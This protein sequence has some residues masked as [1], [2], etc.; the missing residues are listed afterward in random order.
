MGI[1]DFFKG[2]RNEEQKESKSIDQVLNEIQDESRYDDTEMLDTAQEEYE[3]YE[4]DL[5]QE[6]Y[7]DYEEHEDKEKHIEEDIINID[8]GK[9]YNKINQLGK[10][11]ERDS[12]IICLKALCKTAENEE[13]ISAILE[14]AQN[15]IE[16]Y[17]HNEE[18]LDLLSNEEETEMETIS[19]EELIER[20]ELKYSGTEI[21][22][23]KALAKEVQGLNQEI[24]IRK[25]LKKLLIKNPFDKDIINYLD[26]MEERNKNMIFI[27][28]V[29]YIEALQKNFE[30]MGK[31]EIEIKEGIQEIEENFEKILEDLE[32]E[33]DELVK[34]IVRESFEKYFNSRSIDLYIGKSMVKQKEWK[35]YMMTEP[36]FNKG[37][38]NPVDSIT[39]IEALKFCNKVSEYYGYEPAYK[40]EKNRLSKIV[41]RNKMEVNPE[42]ADFSK[43]EGY[44]LPTFLEAIRFYGITNDDSYGWC[45]DS[46]PE[47]DENEI[48]SMT[49]VIFFGDSEEEA[50]KNT[51]K[52]IKKKYIYQ[53]KDINR[54]VIEN[55]IGIYEEKIKNYYEGDSD[56]SLRI[57]RTANCK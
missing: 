21:V 5:A 54:W 42:I 31:E 48:N 18:I 32:D 57:V 7:V 30:L 44:R 9:L 35:R 37:K 10:R 41:Y 3:N 17:P 28:G 55:N 27:K 50:L 20:L 51:T 24:A 52:F 16:K 22:T 8:I 19:L 56:I 6:E 29:T 47:D 36:S 39:W 46:S 53:N 34:E 15:L 13:N 25:S 14:I 40:I 45:Y 23:I 43:V 33:E 26:S 49:D 38:E 2:K 11:Y 1:F 4:E 12:D